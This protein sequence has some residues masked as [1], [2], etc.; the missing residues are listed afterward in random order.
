MERTTM[1]FNETNGLS[2]GILYFCMPVIAFKACNKLGTVVRLANVE[3][4]KHET[5]KGTPAMGK[6][7][8]GLALSIV[9]LAA[10]AA[11]FGQATVVNNL[12]NVISRPMPGSGHDYIKGL[13]ET[14][15]P[16]NGQLSIKIDLPVPA[17]RGLTL[18]YAITYNSGE[19]YYVSSS[20][21][22]GCGG[23]GNPYG[24]SAG[25]PG[26]P[27]STNRSWMGWSD[28]Y[29]YVTVAS[30]QVPMPPYG[31]PCTVTGSYNFFDPTGASHMLGLAAISVMTATQ[32]NSD[33]TCE[34]AT[35]NNTNCFTQGQNGAGAEGCQGG[36]VYQAYAA[37]GDDQVF[38]LSDY[39]T[40]APDTPS[41]CQPAQPAYTV[42]D[43][44][45]TTYFFPAYAGFFQNCG[46]GGYLPSQIEDRN[47]NILQGT[48]TSGSSYIYEIT[49]TS[50]RVL[51]SPW[52]PY[53]GSTGSPSSSGFSV[54][55]MFF[56][57]TWTTTQPNFSE[58]PNTDYSQIDPLPSSYNISCTASFAI[59]PTNPM[60]VLQSLVLPNGQQYTFKY[61]PKYGLVDEIDYPDGGWVKYQWA[62][63][64]SPQLPNPNELATFAGKFTQNTLSAPEVGA[65]NYIYKTPVIVQRTVGYAQGSA[66]A[67]TQ[68]FGPYVT[69][70]EP[71]GA[72]PPNSQCITWANVDACWASK[73]TTVTTTDNVINK[74]S[75]ITYSYTYFFQ[76]PQP[77]SIGQTPA[78]LPV[79]SEIDYTDWG[80]SPSA[81]IEKVNKLW[82]D[83]F[84][85]TQEQTV[86]T[87]ITPN[88]TAQAR[89]S[90]SP[91][92]G[93][94]NPNIPA[95]QSAYAFGFPGQ[96]QSKQEYDYNQTLPSRITTYGYYSFTVPSGAKIAKPNMVRVT[97]G[98]ANWYGESDAEYDNQGVLAP[99]YN[100]GEAVS[101]VANLAQST[102]DGTN[103]GTNT[104]YGR[105]NPTRVV[106]CT[107]SST[108]SSGGV[109]TPCA[110]PTTTYT[111]DET[112]Q[113]TSM[114]PPCGI[115]PCLGITGSNY[116]TTYSYADHYTKLSS[117]QNASYSPGA[118][119]NALLTR[120]T[121][122]L[123]FT[124]NFTYDYNSTYLT[125]ATDEN[126][127]TANY[128]YSDSLN[129]PTTVNYPGGGQTEM[130]YNDGLPNPTVTTC[131]LV[132][133]TQG[134]ACSPTSPSPGWKTSVAVR[135]GLDHVIQTE[136]VSDPEGTDYQSFVFDGEGHTYQA[137][138]PYRSTSDLTYGVSTSYFDALGRPTQVQHP[139]STTEQWSYNGNVTTFTNEDM[140]RWMRT[141]D[142]L[143]RLT[144]V[145]EPNA[146]SM[147][148]NY[149]YDPLNDLLNVT[150]N[151]VSG[152]DTPRVRSFTY[153]SLSQL[154][155]GFNPETGTVEYNYDLNGNVSKKTDA[156]GVA[157]NYTYDA[158]NQ[159]LGKTY[160]NDPS[161]TP[162]SCYQ[163]GTSTTGNTV[164][165]LINEWTQ[166][167]S[168]GA[169]PGSRPANYLSWRGNMQY[170]PMGRLSAAQQQQCIGS[171]CSAPSPYSLSMLY[172]PA[173]DMKSLTNSV[174][175]NL[176]PLTLLSYFDN[177]ARPCLVTSNWTANFPANLF[178]VNPSGSGSSA[179]YAAP[180]ELQNWYVG[181][182]AT[183]ASTPCASTVNTPINL[184][185]NYNKRLWI[186][187]IS[188]TG[189]IP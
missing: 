98:N 55:D 137:S 183:T 82:A 44:N 168:A 169:C 77:N 185:Q 134:A 91:I 115:V 121:D 79:E 88:Q 106:R 14:V 92:I 56:G 57:T 142:G 68:T 43:S 94:D 172:D 127:Q 119:T 110:G 64:N 154:T 100:S 72:T 114:T 48:V 97:D 90:Y 58:Q 130:A 112:G 152:V 73:Q 59:G 5:K 140:N 188:A 133:G 2:I 7:L 162:S 132:S 9:A 16:A 30:V 61:D 123:G 13:V 1:T 117:G 46:G 182:N 179:G 60:S 175:E 31:A 145:Q 84:E 23:L 141:T 81:P 159:L 4:L 65:C 156:R 189:Q 99:S 10:T 36:P 38:A 37:G 116:T 122:P 181:S 163:Y 125:S 155:A 19:L 131:T 149:Q 11:A 78:E 6:K 105:G 103:Y 124:Q 171:S 174:G 129:R 126:L 95:S 96:I 150:Q 118:N 161:N 89:Y 27:G 176:Q 41:D 34:G 93:W 17:D 40:G 136:L 51:F 113:E 173:G 3:E 25:S 63:S 75:T 139:D 80:G 120:I 187:S 62:L 70:W 74:T 186:T 177:A 143:G 53:G 18:P 76:P 85:M 148:T 147:V 170:D 184:Q 15:N 35:Y 21:F 135:D 104:N 49:D 67:L 153:D 54:G 29:P 111:F 101:S 180:G 50:G 178:Q 8:V 167:A 158:L 71:T 151:G 165:R 108:T 26:I 102:Y 39:C 164:E 146:A 166:S 28:T 160:S 52:C 109:T 33:T 42:T 45:G 83:Q 32:F 87:N 128:I 66:P 157:V 144:Q 86:W 12:G 69:N 20:L 24:C 138:N 107:S 47:G 22:V